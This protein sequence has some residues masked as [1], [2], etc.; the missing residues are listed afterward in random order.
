[1]PAID[2]FSTTIAHFL[3]PVAKLLDDPTASEIM[4]NG[5]E[6]I[7]FE[8]GGKL[9]ETDLRFPSEAALMA[10][11]TNIAEYIDRP[12]DAQNP[13]MD[14]RLPDGSR[15]HVIIPPASRSGIVMTIRRFRKA[16]FDLEN[17]IAIGSL[18]PVTAEFLSIA[19]QLHKNIVI[20]GGTGTGKTSM[21]NALSAEIPETERIVVIEDSS[22]LQLSQAHTVYLE[23]Q[24][25]DSNGEGHISIRELFANSLR[26]R[27]DRIVVGEVRRG[28]ALDLVQSMLSGHAGS[29]STVHAN[30]PR[31][32]LTRLETLCL[33]NDADLPVYVAR[34]QV[35]SAIDLVLQIARFS[36]GSRRV[37]RVTEC[38]GLDKDNQYH[39]QDLIRFRGTGTNEDGEIQ[40]VH[41]LTGGV[42]SFASEPSEYGMSDAIKHASQLF[43]VLG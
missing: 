30:T 11:I 17:L 34:Q 20:S 37:V 19:V 15:V 7:W 27:P 42:A 32:A 16:A 28:E 3:T 23:A 8:R 12:I 43:E 35:A 2:I 24:P 5:P 13:T 21:L 4:I 41:E 6:S 14:G 33:L 36:D 18:D 38:W 40:G 1:M 10:T 25:A 22:E 9:E 29:L 26:M 39:W 31:D